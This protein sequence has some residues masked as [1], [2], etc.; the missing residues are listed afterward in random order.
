MGFPPWGNI[1]IPPLFW[2]PCTH[3]GSPFETL[4]H[5]ILLLWPPHRLLVLCV[6][7]KF[8]P[9]QSL[10]RQTTLFYCPHKIHIPSSLVYIHWVV[11]PCDLTNPCSLM[12]T[13]SSRL[14]LIP[15]TYYLG[16]MVFS[17][18]CIRSSKNTISPLGP[19]G[20]SRYLFFAFHTPS[21][22]STSILQP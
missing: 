1:S 9:K 21:L 13:Y 20:P 11:F 12:T 7:L 19:V 3:F 4:F 14:T 5:L 15:C 16:N 6:L 22:I 17:S 8:A 18:L 10:N 2:Y